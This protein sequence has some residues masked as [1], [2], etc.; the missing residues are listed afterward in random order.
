MLDIYSANNQ[1]HPGQ[2]TI[3]EKFSIPNHE[4]KEVWGMRF[5]YRSSWST[6][7]FYPS[8]QHGFCGLL[9]ADQNFAHASLC[10]LLPEIMINDRIPAAC[11]NQKIVPACIWICSGCDQSPGPTARR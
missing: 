9:G 11:V 8:V 10:F 3:D 6:M 1:A 2:P 7:L 4:T 5:C